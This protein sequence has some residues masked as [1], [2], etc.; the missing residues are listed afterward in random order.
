VLVFDTLPG[1][2]IGIAVSM[3]LLLYRSSR[4]NVTRLARG[5]G[6][7]WVDA[8]RHPELSVDPEVVVVRVESGLYFANADHVR[9]RVRALVTPQTRSVVLDGRPRRPS[10]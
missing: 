2:V 1:L 4:P 6:A 3:L 10:T 9:A 8:S 7:M 5:S